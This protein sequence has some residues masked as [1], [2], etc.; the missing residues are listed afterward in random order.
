[1]LMVV[2]LLISCFVPVVVVV[3]G[4]SV[5]H[6]VL[7]LLSLPMLVCCMLAFWFENITRTLVMLCS[8]C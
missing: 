6:V 4:S 8:C 2:W 3:V 7:L 5:D 1:M